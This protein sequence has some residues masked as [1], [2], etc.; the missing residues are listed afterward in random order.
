MI[1]PDLRKKESD[2]IFRM[3]YRADREETEENELTTLGDPAHREWEVVV[4]VLLEHQSKHDPLMLLRLLLYMA[5]LWAEQRRQAEDD[6]MPDGQL[7]IYPVIPLVFYTGEEGWTTALNLDHL[8]DLPEELQRF[9]PHWDTLFLN[10]HR[11]PTTMLTRFSTAVGYALRVFQAESRP[12]A[13]LEVVVQEA[14]AGLEGLSE[15][16]AGQWQRMAWFLLL[17]AFH[18]RE[19]AEYEVLADQIQRTTRASKFAERAE[20]TQMGQTMAEYVKAEGIR[21][22]Q[23][24]AQSA[25]EQARQ[26]GIEIGET[27]GIEIGET[28]GIEIGETRG[29]EIG[30]ASAARHALLILL[31]ARFGEL[32]SGVRQVIEAAETERL[33]SWFAVA[34]TAVSLEAVGIEAQH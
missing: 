30:K 11:T 3:P 32:P 33:E 6:G 13:E 22:G 27:R 5:E 29:I 18:R 10:L 17:W 12:L 26:E 23:S 24:R 25:A 16:Q 20:V 28:R 21:I 1:P 19:R 31:T 2:L 9:V 8:M 4:Y 34:V 7:R 15:E 14:L